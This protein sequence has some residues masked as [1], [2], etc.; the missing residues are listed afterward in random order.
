[1]VDWWL[2][3]RGGG[4]LHTLA[5]CRRVNLCGDC[6]RWTETEMEMQMEMGME[7]E[8]LSLLEWPQSQP[9]W[10]NAFSSMQHATIIAAWPLM[11]LCGSFG[12]N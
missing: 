8:S 9:H 12:D 4:I 1:L 6:E 10:L 5:N 7:S 11:R 3:A 2:V